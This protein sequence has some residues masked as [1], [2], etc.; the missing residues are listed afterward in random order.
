M[1]QAPRAGIPINPGHDIYTLCLIT[2][3]GTLL[4]VGGNIS[5]EVKR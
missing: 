4:F 2:G 3:E 5:A 1:K